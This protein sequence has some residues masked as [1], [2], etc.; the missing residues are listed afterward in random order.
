MA[1]TTRWKID[2]R[3]LGNHMEQTFL[4][5]VNQRVSEGTIVFEVID[6]IPSDQ[7]RLD[8]TKVQLHQ[9]A[10]LPHQQR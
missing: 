4:M 10:K 7:R 3:L 9:L 2:R 1:A 6:L 8:R 5:S